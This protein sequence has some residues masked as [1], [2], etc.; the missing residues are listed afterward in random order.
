M[1]SRAARNT[2]IPILPQQ[3]EQSTVAYLVDTIA[4]QPSF[5]KAVPAKQEGSKARLNAHHSTV[6]QPCGA[7]QSR[8]NEIA[9]I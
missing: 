7:E 4:G 8:V 2:V 6:N 1:G 5:T 9:P 3:T